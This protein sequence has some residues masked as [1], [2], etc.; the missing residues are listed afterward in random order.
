MKEREETMTIEIITK[1]ET[2]TFYVS[3]CGYAWL[4]DESSPHELGTQ[5]CEGGR[6]RGPTVMVQK[7]AERRDLRKWVRQYQA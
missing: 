5:I 3:G 4:K 6:F 1:S 7:G 2:F